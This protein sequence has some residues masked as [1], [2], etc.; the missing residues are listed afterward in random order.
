[1]GMFDAMTAA[2]GT[3]MYMAPELLEANYERS[4]VYVP[5]S[6]K[7]DIYAFG[8]VLWELLTT[9]VPYEHIPRHANVIEKILQGARPEVKPSDAEIAPKGFLDLME[10]CWDK[11]TST[12]P[13]INVLVSS[14]AKMQAGDK[15][16]ASKRSSKVKNDDISLTSPLI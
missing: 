10:R 8:I 3:P 7:T 4:H 1:M 6:F 12:R 15:K 2:R 13:D 11:E 9:R 14:L 5:M 16:T